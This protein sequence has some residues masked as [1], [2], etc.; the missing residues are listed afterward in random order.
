MSQAWASLARTSILLLICLIISA[1]NGSYTAFEDDVDL[2]TDTKTVDIEAD[3]AEKI[4]LAVL[5]AAYLAHYRSALYDFLDASDLP[6][7]SAAETP[8]DTWPVPNTNTYIRDCDSG[9]VQYEFTRAA[10]EA[11]KVGD[12]IELKFTNCAQG[13]R[14]YNGSLVGRYTKI[15]G[16]NTRF[17]TIDTQTCLA[18]L[19]EELDLTDSQIIYVSGD[20]LK[21]RNVAD[22]VEVD[23]IDY[24]FSDNGGNS[25]R[26]DKVLETRII[27]KKE[28]VII[29]NSI[30]EPPAGA[31]TSI[32]GD[33]L[34]SVQSQVSKKHACQL[35]ERTLSVTLDEFSSEEGD[36]TT[37]LNGSVTLYETQETPARVNQEIV[38]SSFQTRVEQGRVKEVF[39]MSDY[40]VQKAVQRSSNTYSYL[41]DGFVSAS[42]LQGKV[43]LTSTGKL[44]GRSEE[45]YPFSGSME[46]LGRGL[47]RVNLVA[48]NLNIRLQVD[49]DGDSNG[50]GFGDIDIFIDT[51]WQDLFERS[52]KE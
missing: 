10:G 33:Q 12:R 41:F 19:Q 40:R 30:L 25:Q 18:N 26:T 4:T 15:E 47:E 28:K 7:L 49:F 9:A 13:D 27:G 37:T 21:F 36:L 8:P 34:Y 5:Q 23:V 17:V 31:I 14:I 22:T 24:I 3:N 50:T 1:C 35:Y 38:N 44:L 39:Q 32:N 42:A 46:I 20:D 43:Q 11:H 45:L 2:N 51:T 29:V 48:T 16:L 52:F 6:E